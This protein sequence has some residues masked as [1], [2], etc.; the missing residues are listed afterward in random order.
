MMLMLR[1]L[2]W[3]VRS[4]PVWFAAGAAAAWFLDPDQGEARRARLTGQV[5]G[6]APVAGPTD[7]GGA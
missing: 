3:A 5:Q 6:L 4:R 7:S 1:V 2:W